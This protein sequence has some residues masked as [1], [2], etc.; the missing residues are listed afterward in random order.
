[1]IRS[2][3]QVTLVYLALVTPSFA[4][5]SEGHEY[6]LKCDSNGYT[7]NSIGNV[8]RTI[9]TGAGTRFYK[10]KEKIFLGRS[11]DAYHKLYGIGEWCWA[12]GGFQASFPLKQFDFPRQELSC[13]AASEFEL[14]CR[15]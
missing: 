1:M 2:V 3:L 9:G 6:N 5:V 15:C 4:Y 13:E 8:V 7:L 14:N 11:C 12:N 10:S